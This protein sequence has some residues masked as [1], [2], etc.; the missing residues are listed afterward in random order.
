MG[1]W[2][3]YQTPRMC[4]RVRLAAVSTFQS[5]VIKSLC[6]ETRVHQRPPNQSADSSPV[7][8]EV[9]QWCS[10][11]PSVCWSCLEFCTHQSSWWVTD[12]NK[13]QVWNGQS[14]ISNLFFVVLR[15]LISVRTPR[16][17]NTARTVLIPHLSS[18]LPLQNKQCPVCVFTELFSFFLQK[19][20]KWLNLRLRSSLAC[21]QA[22][23]F[24]TQQH[25]AQIREERNSHSVWCCAEVQLRSFFSAEQGM[26]RSSLGLEND[27]LVLCL[28]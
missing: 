7:S 17:L 3:V 16:G 1:T 24:N 21:V 28:S 15:H 2:T 19:K 8:T 10:N 20:E 13:H 18:P 11:S 27:P 6:V 12:L 14:D 25:A 4:H 26:W 23:S 22:Q 5:K 9:P